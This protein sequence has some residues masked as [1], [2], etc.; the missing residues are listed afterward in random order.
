MVL[1]ARII[2]LEYNLKLLKMKDK[3]RLNI[4][5]KRE[6]RIAYHTRLMTTL[7]A[8]LL[9]CLHINIIVLNFIEISRIRA[10]PKLLA[11]LVSQNNINRITISCN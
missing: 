2:I 8:A 6:M 3:V 7:D 5:Y 1:V 11:K 4:I 9:F 10:S